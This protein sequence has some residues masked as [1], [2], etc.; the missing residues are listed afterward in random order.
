MRP[1]ILSR[2]RRFSVN[3]QQQGCAAPP[4]RRNLSTTPRQHASLRH[5]ERDNSSRHVVVILKWIANLP[6]GAKTEIMA[7]EPSNQKLMVEASLA[8]SGGHYSRF[9]K[10][11]STFSS[12]LAPKKNS[13]NM[14]TK[15]Q[16]R[17]KRMWL[18]GYFHIRADTIISCRTFS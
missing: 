17:T 11:H 6:G 8:L 12:F 1:S 3:R 9:N 4:E 16:K 5:N 10:I 18:V 14:S 13:R 7:M 15:R 2:L